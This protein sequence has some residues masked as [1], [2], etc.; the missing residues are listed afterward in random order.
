MEQRR[1]QAPPNAEFQSVPG[2]ANVEGVLDACLEQTSQFP[3][4][5]L[6]S[7][8]AA[9]LGLEE[10]EAADP[11]GPTTFRGLA[12]M[13][14]LAQTLPRDR[15]VVVDGS[16]GTCVLVVWAHHVL[17]LD[18][19]VRIPKRDAPGQ[20]LRDY[21]DIYFGNPPATVTIRVPQSSDEEGPRVILLESSSREILFS[22]LQDPDEEQVITSS[23]K[24]LARG[25][26]MRVLEADW[27]ARTKREDKM[28]I[29]EGCLHD[30]MLVCVALAFR[31]SQYIYKMLWIDESLTAGE[32]G[33][34]DDVA[35][36]N[37][38][39]SEGHAPDWHHFQI[40]ETKLFEAA[41]FLFDLKNISQAEL[42]V[43]IQAHRMI[44]TSEIPEPSTYAAVRQQCRIDPAN[45]RYYLRT[46]SRM[47]LL[48]L[49]FAHVADLS[50]AEGLL[51][52][53]DIPV[54]NLEDTYLEDKIWRWDGK[55]CLRIRSDTWFRTYLAL[56][57][58][59]PPKQGPRGDRVA[60]LVSSRGW[61]AYLPTFGTPDPCDVGE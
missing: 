42:T 59:K 9:K 45:W 2:H 34:E 10:H 4:P 44:K 37:L 50:D 17:G 3:W 5:A 40:P 46:I 39:D 12:L 61:S 38:T 20:G 56:A 49:T 36:L 14:P 27:Q 15:E 26:A 57:A 32:N 6:L 58:D 19:V 25:S 22:I 55:K 16:T 13:L 33:V 24:R 21:D 23:A 11:I 8:V 52:N 7:S 30:M 41:R 43:Y 1:D 51:I 31:A 18:V 47:S 53:R 29:Q 48:V 28:D 35:D 60:S 54:L